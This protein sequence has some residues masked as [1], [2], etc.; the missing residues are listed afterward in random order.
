MLRYCYRL[1]RFHLIPRALLLLLVMMAGHV[2]QCHSQGF[3]KAQGKK[4]VDG[5]GRNVLLRGMGLGGWMVQEGY[6]LRI[7]GQGQQHKI[8]ERIAAILT[9]QQTQE[10]YDTW[11][12][13][14][15]RKIDVDSMHAWGFNSIRLPMHY[16]LYTLPVELEPVPGENSWLQKGFEMTDSLLSWCKANNL[17]LVLDLHAAPGGQ[18][19]DLNISDR[20]D[21]KPSLW[22]TEANRNKTIALWKK[23]AGRYANEPWIGA[24]DILN[25]PNIG[26]SDPVADPHGLAEKGN[27]PLK[28]LLVDITTAIRSVDRNHL[29]IIE[30]NGWGNNYNGIFPLWDNN[31]A[32]SF[33]KYWNNNDVASIST[34]AGIT[35]S[36]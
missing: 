31:M 20:D 1:Y 12:S 32:M 30:G 18:G 6:M 33:H 26:F 8:R 19:N 29:V 10:F 16:N 21:S 13:N 23:L 24:Y 15:T 28:K 22:E 2:Y 7:N 25:E 17:Y 3:L 4:I 35:Q 5:N 27:E 11:L 14:H 9:P 36:V 34:D